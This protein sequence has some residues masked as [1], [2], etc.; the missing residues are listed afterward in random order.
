[1]K[2]F[3]KSNLLL[4]LIGLLMSF[5]ITIGSAKT[6]VPVLNVCAYS[7]IVVAVVSLMVEA[8]RLLIKEC[9]R[10]QWTRIALWL[11]GGIVGTVL[12]LLLS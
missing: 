10:W 12:G 9:A 1:M 11:S 3:S 7:L 8:F 4:S 2:T 6:D 5:F